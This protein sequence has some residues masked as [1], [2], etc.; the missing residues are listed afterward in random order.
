MKSIK[1]FSLFVSACYIG[2]GVLFFLYPSTSKEQL[3]MWLSY[4][5]L[6]IGSIEIIIYFLRKKIDAFFRNDF[7][8]GLL[9]ITVGILIYTNANLFYDLVYLSLAIII[10]LSG[11]RKLQDGVDA[12][13]LNAGSGLLY[14]VL[15]LISIAIGL[16]TI[17]HGPKLQL[18]SLDYLIGAGLLYSGVTDLISE[19]FLSAKM[20]AHLRNERKQAEQA[21]L[22]QQAKEVE[23]NIVEE[24][25]LPVEENSELEN[26]EENKELVEE[27]NSNNI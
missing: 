7:M 13:R 22:Q 25:V 9:L 11:Y 17:I 6:I 21:K 16:I 23:T 3:S 5:T 26:K 10:M 19:I 24:D 4:A 2:S 20:Y 18:V 14:I 12:Y 1:W 8:V 27:E 15:A